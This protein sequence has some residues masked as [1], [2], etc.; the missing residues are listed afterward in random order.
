MNDKKWLISFAS[1]LILA[2]LILYTVHY[3]IFEDLHHI[4]VFALHELAFVP[5]EVLLVTLVI[6][7]MLDTREKKSRL[8]KMNMV[9]GTF[10]SVTG[11][12]LLKCFSDHNPN[13]N[14]IRNKLAINSNWKTENF[15]TIEKEIK[16]YQFKIDICSMDLE[17]LKKYLLEKEDFLVRLLEN[18]VLLEHEEFTELLRATFHLT[19][20]LHN[21]KDLKSCPETDK[22]HLAGDINRVYSLLAEEWIEYMKYLRFSYPYLFSLAIRTNPFGENT[23]ATVRQ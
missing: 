4:G 10:F 6:H 18:P 14:S 16:N 13:I 12:N 3:L 11:T 23:D 22:N 7:R 20:E 1:V 15:D 17:I 9:I 8:E 21:R 5:I 2:S 19:E